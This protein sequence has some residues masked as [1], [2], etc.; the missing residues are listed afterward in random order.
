MVTGIF[1]KLIMKSAEGRF[2]SNKEDSV[3][4]KQYGR[5][6]N[7]AWKRRQYLNINKILVWEFSKNRNISN[8][9]LFLMN[10]IICLSFRHSIQP[11]DIFFFPVCHKG[12]LIWH[13][14]IFRKTHPN[15]GTF[16][17]CKCCRLGKCTAMVV[18]KFSTA[19]SFIFFS[20]IYF[21]CNDFH[22]V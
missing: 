19:I 1:N 15:N 22:S 5:T 3:Q 17:W 13:V 8:I 4:V 11:L 18:F 14:T 2:H 7:K 9:S 6:K 12:H 21:L 10:S 20:F 16:G